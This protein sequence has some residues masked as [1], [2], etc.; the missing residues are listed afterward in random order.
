[1]RGEGAGNYRL[2]DLEY[3]PGHTEGRFLYRILPYASWH[4]TDFLDVHVEGQGYGYTGGSQYLGRISLYQGFVEGR[5]PGSDLLALKVGRQDF[6]YGS[7]FILG[8]DSWFKGLSFDAARLRIKPAEALTVDLL[9]GW[10][11]HPGA[12]GVKATWAGGY[13]SYKINEGAR[14]LR[15]TASTIPAPKQPFRRTSEYLRGLAPPASLG[16]GFP[17]VRARLS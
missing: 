11:P 16:T 3:N 14:S 10:Y 12:D 4:P 13:A 1:M 2:Q 15:L 17:G 7:V 9:G 5:L 6:A 8:N